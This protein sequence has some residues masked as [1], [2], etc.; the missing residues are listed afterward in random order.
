MSR[1]LRGNI[2]NRRKPDHPALCRENDARQAAWLGLFRPG[3]HYP[4]I[5]PY[6]H[7]RENHETQ[8]FR[9]RAEAR[10][11]HGQGRLVAGG[12][13]DG[14]QQ[15]PNQ[16]LAHDQAGRHQH[17]AAIGPFG[18]ALV[19]LPGGGGPAAQR[20]PSRSQASTAPTTMGAL[21]DGGK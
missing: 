11:D 10:A 17:A 9:G 6:G 21:A 4:A 18:I 5:N 1:R 15:H 16:A 13:D 19:V 2:G 3:P 8:P 14:C 20:A 7:G 12:A